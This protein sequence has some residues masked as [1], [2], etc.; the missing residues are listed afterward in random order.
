MDER[1]SGETTRF[2]FGKPVAVPV[3]CR[4][5]SGL[6]R[7]RCAGRRRDLVGRLAEAAF[8]ARRVARALGLPRDKVH[9]I[10]VPGPG[11]YGRNDAGDAGIDAALLSKPVGR[12]VRVQGMRYEGHG[13]GPPRARPRSTA[14]APPST[15]TARWI[16]YVFESKGFSCIDIDTNESDPAY[17]LAGQLMGLPLKPLQGFGVSTE[18]YGFANKRLAWETIPPLLDRASPLR[19]AHLRD[20]VGPQIQFASESFIDELAAAIGADPVAFR[21]RYLKEPRDIA[22]VKAAAERA[23]WEPRPSPRPDRSGDTLTGRGIAYAQR[24]GAVVA[25][26]A[27]VEIAPHR[28][29]V[30]AQIHR[31]A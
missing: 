22:V 24:S 25:I 30:G 17:S 19:T 6:R 26:V 21:L 3:G 28:Q 27:E 18:S 20:P 1:N 23:G 2:D 13:W 8:R 5:G 16:G 29:G 31:R 15:R 4:H 10:W 7:R 11:S 12:P 9:G 14:P